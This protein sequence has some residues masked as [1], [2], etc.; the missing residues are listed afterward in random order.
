[1]K[2]WLNALFYPEKCIFCGKVLDENET[3]LCRNCRKTAP[4]FP[5]SKIKLSFLAQWTGLWYYKENVRQS[6]LRYKFYG[7]RSYA[8]VYGRLLAMKLQSTDNT[9]WDVLSW[10]PISRLRRWGRGFDQSQLLAEAVSRE[11]GVP[12]VQTLRKV[13]N[14]R[15]QSGLGTAAHRRANVLGA[16]EAVD[17]ANWSGKRILLL[18][19]VVTTG[20]TASE[21]AKTLLLA[22][23][24]EIQLAT[25]A[26]ATHDK[27]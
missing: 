21:C 1:M 4:E 5:G 12:A 7:R 13:R 26:V 22:G 23:A 17:S 18:D 10:V 3:D 19:D 6:L 20:A 25:I 11:L 16:Y 24:K 15:P 27:R 9:Q 2:A 14:T 8:A